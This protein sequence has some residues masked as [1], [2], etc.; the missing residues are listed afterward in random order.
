MQIVNDHE[1]NAKGNPCKQKFR[2]YVIVSRDRD[3]KSLIFTI[4]II[5]LFRD[6]CY[7]PIVDT[8]EP[9]CMY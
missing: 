3:H 4:N 1:P 5:F 7:Y 9:F 8:L 2:Q 6:I